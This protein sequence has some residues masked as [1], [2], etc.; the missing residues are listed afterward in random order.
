VAKEQVESLGATFVMVESEETKQA[1]TKGGYAKEMSEDYKRRQAELIAET[2]KKQD[3]VICTALIPGRAAPR[4][5]TEDMLRSM[6]P[7]SVI[8]DLAVEQGGNC[9][10]SEAGRVVE[11][12]G[13]KIVGYRNVPS[14][15]AV[16]ASAL[17][18]RNLLNFVTLL[19]AKEGGQTKIDWDDEI[20]RAVALTRDGS[21]IHPQFQPQTATN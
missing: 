10:G 13:V 17:Y 8:V 11:V 20:V 5:I 16:D 21:I 3:V 19:S 6:K 9:A 7:G 15:I 1:E 14:R 12:S 18:A 4:L 2:L